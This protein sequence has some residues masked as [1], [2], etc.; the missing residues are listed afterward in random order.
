MRHTMHCAEE[1]FGRENM[2]TPLAWILAESVFAGN[3]LTNYGG[4]TPYNARCGRQPQMLPPL[5][6][7]PTGESRSF[8]HRVREIALQKIIES[9]AIARINRALKTAVTPAGETIGPD[10]ARY[11]QGGTEADGGLARTDCAVI[12][13]RTAAADTLPPPGIPTPFR[14]FPMESKAQ[15]TIPL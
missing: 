4:A 14:R 8:S 6:G 7:M 5:Q 10:T 13:S 1:Q 2:D 9:T 15:P 3:C 11:G 12:C